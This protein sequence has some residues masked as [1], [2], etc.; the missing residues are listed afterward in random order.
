MDLRHPL[1]EDRQSSCFTDDQICPLDNDDC[2]EERSV[3]CQLDFLTLL[4]GLKY[5]Q[6]IKIKTKVIKKAKKTRSV[7]A[8]PLEGGRY[9]C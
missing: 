6:N 3:A 5:N 2:Y 4:V 8:V 1:M 7:V 9:L